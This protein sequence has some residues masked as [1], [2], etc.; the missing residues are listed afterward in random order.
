LN[1]ETTDEHTRQKETERDQ[2]YTQQQH[3]LYAASIHQAG[4]P[5]HC[6][7]LPLQGPPFDPEQVFDDPEPLYLTYQVS[8]AGHASNEQLHPQW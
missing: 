3:L 4:E 7:G 6:F 8:P 1:S 2:R 5:K